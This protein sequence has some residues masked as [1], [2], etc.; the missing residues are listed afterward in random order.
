MAGRGGAQANLRARKRPRLLNVFEL[1]NVSKRFDRVLALDAVTL[2]V[3]PRSIVGLLGKNG[4]GKTTL[5]RHVTG[6]HLPS[7]G[8]CETFGC[9][10]DKLGPGEL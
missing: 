3:P 4:S 9:P 6:L 10:T 8:R 7:S 5:L 1:Q 2:A